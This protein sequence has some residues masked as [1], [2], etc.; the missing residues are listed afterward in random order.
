MAYKQLIE[1]MNKGHTRKI[2]LGQFSVDMMERLAQFTH[3]YPHVLQHNMSLN[4]L[5]LD[6]LDFC[7]EHN[8]ELQAYEPLG[9]FRSNSKNPILQKMADKYKCSIKNLLIAYLLEMGLVPVVNYNNIQDIN[10]LYDAKMI[11]LEPADIEILMSM[12]K[13]KS[14]KRKKLK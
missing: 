2:G 4:H 13:F 3:K 11:Q 14:K 9:E 6:L 10:E 1:C 12:N 8:I 7:K 5:D